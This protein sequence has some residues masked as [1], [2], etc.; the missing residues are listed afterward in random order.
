MNRTLGIFAKAPVAGTVK[1]RMAADTSPR[2]SSWAAEVYEACLLDVLDRVQALAVHRVLVYEPLNAAE[3]FAQAG[4]NRFTLVAQ[5]GETLGDRLNHF[6]AEQFR[7]GARAVVA[8]GADSPSLPVEFIAQAYAELARADVV[9]GPCTDGGYYLIGMRRLVPELFASITWSTPQVL[10]QTIRQIQHLP[11]TL[12]L[13]PP[14]YDV[15]TLADWQ[16]LRG[17]VAAML[18][19]G[20]DPGL[21]RVL[22]KLTRD[23]ASDS[24][25]RGM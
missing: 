10:E 25:S 8:L 21:P 22:A 18:R 1:T 3:W 9:L 7:C 5:E 6:F 17:H 4:Q 19:A 15:D 12:A 20:V 16:C 14:W 11:V 24:S 23:A 2:S 13:L